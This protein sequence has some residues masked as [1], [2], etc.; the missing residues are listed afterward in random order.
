MAEK[1]DPI[2]W[3]VR[4]TAAL[5]GRLVLGKPPATETRRFERGSGMTGG[6]WHEEHSYD[7]LPASS[8][9]GKRVNNME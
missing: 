8:Q 3:P 1:L 7:L 9:K 2:L 5:A 6:R 4:I